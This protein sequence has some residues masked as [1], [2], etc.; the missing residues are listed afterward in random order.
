MVPSAARRP[1]LRHS[2]AVRS[3]SISTLSMRK[4]YRNAATAAACTM[5]DSNARAMAGRD[6]AHD[7]KA[8]PASCT[9]R[10]RHAI[11]TLEHALALMQRNAR[12]V[13][14]DLE[15]RMR[16]ALAGPHRDVAAALRILERVVHQVRQRFAQEKCI[17]FD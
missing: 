11:E 2:S 3:T 8:E 13:V 16:V 14:F 4:C 17:A 15:K 12:A 7:G 5:V 6:L 10:T 9:R 1:C